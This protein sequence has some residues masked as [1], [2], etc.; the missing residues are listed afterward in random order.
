MEKEDIVKYWIESSDSDFQVME[1]LFENDITSGPYSWG[2]WWSK[3][4]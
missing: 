4:Y 2:T 1:S 3:N